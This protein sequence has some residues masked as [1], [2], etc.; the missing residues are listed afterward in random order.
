MVQLKSSL[1]QHI[2]SVH[3]EII[4]LQHERSKTSLDF[5]KVF[6]ALVVAN[7]QKRQSSHVFED[8]TTCLLL[9][10]FDPSNQVNFS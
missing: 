10:V 2:N 6:P 8:M 3:K 9:W 1:E 5:T 7:S 4:R